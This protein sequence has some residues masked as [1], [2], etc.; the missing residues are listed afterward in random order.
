MTCRQLFIAA[1][2]VTAKG[3]TQPKSP[4]EDES[5][6]GVSGS[7]HKGMKKLSIRSGLQY[8]VPEEQGEEMRE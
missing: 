8:R 7:P 4:V 3:W 1:L 6:N 5:H 2:L